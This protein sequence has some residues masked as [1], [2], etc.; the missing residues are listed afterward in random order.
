MSC[1]HLILVWLCMVYVIAITARHP[2]FAFALG[3][4][5]GGRTP[6]NPRLVPYFNRQGQLI[7]MVR[8]PPNNSREELEPTMHG[9]SPN[10]DMPDVDGGPVRPSRRL[11][12]SVPQPVSSTPANITPETWDGWPDGRFQCQFLPQQVT[13]T[14]QL[15]IHWVCEALQGHRGSPTALTWQKGK[16]IHRRCIGVLECCSPSCSFNLQVAP[17]ARGVDLHRQLQKTCLCG[18][19]T[20]LRSC[21]IEYSTY[22]YRIGAFFVNSGNHTHPRYT[23]S[24]TYRP[25]EPL[26]FEEYV[27]KRPISLRDSPVHVVGIFSS[28]IVF[29]AHSSQESHASVSST[30]SGSDSEWGGIQELNGDMS[31]LLTLNCNVG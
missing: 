8:V 30:S 31:L 29:I 20:R 22:F 28:G 25:R 5:K 15:A 7:G 11:H 17:A 26:E 23:H 13:D 19:A 2:S 4:V 14:N 21:G 1:R 3:A 9:P 10:N 12:N 16:A 6:R 24:L 27:A 18:E